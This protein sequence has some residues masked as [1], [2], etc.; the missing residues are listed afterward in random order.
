MNPLGDRCYLGAYLALGLLTAA[1][2]ERFYVGHRRCGFE[3][4]RSGILGPRVFQM[5]MDAARFV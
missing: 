4:R 5:D 1:I 2:H 3:S